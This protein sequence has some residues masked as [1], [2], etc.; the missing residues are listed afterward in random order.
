MRPLSDIREITE[1]SLIDMVNYAK[2]HSEQASAVHQRKPSRSNSVN[3]GGSIGRNKSIKPVEPVGQRQHLRT[4]SA[5]NVS[6]SYS[7]TPEQSSCYAIPQS[8]VPRRSSS[9]LHAKRSHSRKP[10]IRSVRGG[11]AAG[12]VSKLIVTNH[13]P[14]RSPVKEVSS[15]L[16]PVSSD[17]ARKMPSKTFIRSP[18]LTDVLE[19][20]IH[21]HPRVKL[22]LQTSAPLF[23]GGGSIEGHV[24]ITVDDNERYKHRRSLGV[25]TTTIDLV[26]FEE[27]AGNRRAVF[28]ALGTELLDTSHPPPNTMVEPDNPLS[29]G[30]RFWTLKPSLSALPFMLSLPLDTGPP[31]FSSKQANIRFLLCVTM[32]IRDA[33]K[34]YRVRTSHDICV[35][36][37]YDP[38]R[39]LTSLPSPLIASDELSLQRWGAVETLNL[40]AGLYRQVWV[41][42]GSIFVDLHISNKT[43]RPV[44]RVDLSLE[45]AVLCYKHA[46]AATLEK[47]SSQV[48]IS[49]TSERL[50]LAK[51]SQR[52]DCDGWSGTEVYTSDARTCELQVP[53][54]HATVKCG[55]YFE[56][57]YFLNVAASLSNSK[58]V[59]VQLPII[60]IHMNSLDVLPNSVAQVAAAIEEKR[61]QQRQKTAAP[62]ARRTHARQRSG[63]SPARITEIGRRPSCSQGRAFAAPRQQSLD[64]RRAEQVQMDN[65]QYMLDVSPRK[66]APREHQRP[67]RPLYMQNH[68]SAVSFGALSLERKSSTSGSLFGSIR[69]HTPPPRKRDAQPPRIEIKPDVENGG[70]RDRLRRMQ[71]FDSVHSKK[72]ISRVRAKRLHKTSLLADNVRPT[73]KYPPIARQTSDGV[74]RYH[75][76]PHT[77]GLGLTSSIESAPAGPPHPFPLF[78]SMPSSMAESRPATAFTFREKLDRSRFEFK[79]VRRRASGGIRGKG[80]QWLEKVR[81][82]DGEGVMDGWL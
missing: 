14:S 61:F 7:S 73:P 46:A 81:Q 41:S 43:H 44:K 4:Q 80:K 45:R 60:L 70:L 24:K 62:D 15:K 54:G 9:Q 78:G 10:S 65:L 37:T 77:I 16:N 53:R 36:P 69:Y 11:T 47:M 56:V 76:A 20:P 28:L 68:S 6:S 13:G 26:G 72:S 57:R 30:Q 34:H 17:V 42:G 75:I 32:T 63:S 71:S 22:E 23:V 12:N 39:A 29:Q 31:P 33:G 74:R 66:N 5:E 19:F 55:K 49:E 38:E 21:R 40:T 18:V 35:V 2:R 1:P 8:S 64:R 3:R 58:V 50:I 27:V 51:T 59:S 79:A 52:H 82:R 48:R 25:A 67:P